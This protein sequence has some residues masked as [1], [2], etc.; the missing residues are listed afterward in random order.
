MSKKLK[1]CVAIAVA[2]V[3]VYT[4]N[5]ANNFS[6]KVI[7]SE[8][9]RPKNVI[10]MIADGMNT[11]ALTLARHINGG[12]LAMDEISV[13]AVN[14]TWA[15][16]PITDSAP[17]STAMSTGN[18]T[19]NKYIGTS[20]EDKPLATVLEAAE[21]EGKATGLI[22][23]SEIPHATPAGF[24]AHTTNRSR[25]DDI[26]RQMVNND[27]EVVLGGG[28]N[29]KTDELTNEIKGRIDEAGYDFVQDKEAML[30]YD[31]N[32]LW[33]AFAKAD[34]DYDIDREESGN[35]QPSLSEMTNKAVEVLSKDEDGFMLMVE[36]SKVDWAAHANTP[37]AMVSDI[38]AFDNA[39]KEAL[40]F[41][42]DR[43][44]TVVIV[45]TDHGNSGLSIGNYENTE[46]M[47]YEKLDY[48]KNFSITEEFFNN[49]IL[50][51]IGS[52]DAKVAQLVEMYYGVSGLTP[53]EIAEV[54]AGNLNRVLASRTGIGFTTG[55]HTGENV[56]LGIYAPDSVK[57]LSG[58]VE[59]TNLATYMA[60]LLFGDANRLNELTNQLYIDGQ[61]ALAKIGAT[62]Q[63]DTSNP[64]NIKAIINKDNNV[65]ELELFTNDYTLNGEAKSLKSV[66]PYM[67]KNDINTG[68]FYIPQELIDV[69]SGLQPLET[70][71]NEEAKEK[72]EG[73]K[74]EDSKEDSKLEEELKAED[75]KEEVSSDENKEEAEKENALE[76]VETSEENVSE[77]VA[78]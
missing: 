71:V 11:D 47:S 24:S 42:K 66:M 46:G 18:K 2:L 52:Q 38:I 45:T 25:Y 77:E 78:N 19:E 16:G 65:I 10:M 75:S 51:S 9:N 69:V 34:L 56:Y 53:E 8:Q 63:L 74:V 7:A 32:K 22:A 70:K 6:S 43:E 1:K 50:P 14:T 31:G 48:Y 67:Y 64:Q 3:G 4:L 15:R 26:L 29:L 44:D 54:R 68:R 27:L 33:G 73:L 12:S 20:V 72:N 21:Q 17:A 41:A 13:G 36:G 28:F 35:N 59:N 40:D 55:G 5:L 30:N 76:N 58:V 60:D 49:E 37:S 61:E 39:V 57:K 62:V 23:T